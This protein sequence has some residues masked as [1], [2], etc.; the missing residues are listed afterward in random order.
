VTL[1]SLNEKTWLSNAYTNAAK[2]SRIESAVTRATEMAGGQISVRSPA[3]PEWEAAQKSCAAVS[4][5]TNIH[6]GIRVAV[7]QIGAQRRSPR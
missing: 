4:P 1:Y 5:A 2:Y 7:Q 6:P 3:L